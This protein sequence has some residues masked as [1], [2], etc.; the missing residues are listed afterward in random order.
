MKKM[1]ALV[2]TLSLATGLSATSVLGNIYGVLDTLD[3]YASTVQN[4]WQPNEFRGNTW[5][6]Y[7]TIDDPYKLGTY[8]SSIDD[9]IKTVYDF[10][11]G[12]YSIDNINGIGELAITKINPYI[13]I[14]SVNGYEVACFQY[15]ITGN[16]FQIFGVKYTIC[17]PLEAF[18]G[19]FPGIENT[20]Y[21]MGATSGNTYCRVER[22]NDFMGELRIWLQAPH[23]DSYVYV[24]ETYKQ[25]GVN[26]TVKDWM[27]QYDH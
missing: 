5:N 23:G 20:L 21:V 19:V 11:D 22:N 14:L 9:E 3:N 7:G 2:L 15:E 1:I 10:V 13:V 17:L 8:Y 6:E 12:R 26:V 25:N 18:G 4:T 16:V 24:K 27:M